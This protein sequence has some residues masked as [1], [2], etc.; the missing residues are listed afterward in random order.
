ML[1]YKVFFEG[2]SGK[3]FE[4]VRANSYV[5][6]ESMIATKYPQAFFISAKAP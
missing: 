4:F 3:S 5:E 6:A 2:V 1:S